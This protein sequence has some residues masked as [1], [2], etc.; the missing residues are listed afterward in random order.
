M[1]GGRNGVKYAQAMDAISKGERYWFDQQEIVELL[2]HN[3]KSQVFS[4]AE[5]YFLLFFEVCQD[6]GTHHSGH[7]ISCEA[8]KPTKIAQEYRMK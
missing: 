2:A 7:R 3:R 4:P 1:H 5:Q 6:P 8:N